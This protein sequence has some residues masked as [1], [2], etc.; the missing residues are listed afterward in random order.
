MILAPPGGNQPMTQLSDT[1]TIILS[2]ATQRPDGNL[3]PLPGSLRGGAAA[4]VVTAFLGRGLVREEVTDSIRPADAA[5]NTIWRKGRARHAAQHHRRRPQGARNRAGGGAVSRSPAAARSGPHRLACLGR[6][7]SAATAEGPSASHPAPR[8]G[9]TR[10]G[11]K[12]AALIAMLRRPKG[13]TIG[14]VVEAT[15]WQRTRFAGRW[16]AR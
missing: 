4:K 10:E 5:F 11:T 13:A 14:E 16:P 15:G 8:R 2:A 9:K 6:I 12:Q 1:Q 3:L 7:L